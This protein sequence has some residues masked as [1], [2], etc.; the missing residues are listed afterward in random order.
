MAAVKGQGSWEVLQ[1]VASAVKHQLTE[2]QTVKGHCYTEVLL[3]AAV[4]GQCSFEVLQE[5]TSSPSNSQC[6]CE[7]LQKAASAVKG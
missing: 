2:T 3:E 7:V 4:K 1:E 5:T 6:S